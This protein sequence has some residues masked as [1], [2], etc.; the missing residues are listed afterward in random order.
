MNLVPSYVYTYELPECAPT[1]RSAAVHRPGAGAATAADA[2]WE[3]QFEHLL[4]QDEFVRA[5]PAT[6]DPAEATWFY[7]PAFFPMLEAGAG[8]TDPNYEKW[9]KKKVPMKNSWECIFDV[10]T[11]IWN[12]KDS[13]GVPYYSRNAALDHLTVYGS[14]YPS[15]LCDV[16]ECLIESFDFLFRNVYI[17]VTGAGSISFRFSDRVFHPFSM[18][19]VLRYVTTPYPTALDCHDLTSRPRTTAVVFFGSANTRT[20]SFFKNIS[21]FSQ[22]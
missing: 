11:D 21:R 5:L 6:V 22:L 7:I 12:L 15:S 1:A 3:Q 14:M 8:M 19:P 2:L 13:K 4:F 16:T 9:L 18:Y 17:L 10:F 20:R